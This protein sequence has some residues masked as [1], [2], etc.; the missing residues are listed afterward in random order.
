V[1]NT[2]EVINARGGFRVRMFICAGS[3]E[4]I[5]T[6][7]HAALFAGRLDA[8][9]FA[10]RV[11]TARNIARKLVYYTANDGQTYSYVDE[12]W[13]INPRYWVWEA[14]QTSAYAFMHERPT[15]S[16]ETV[17]RPIIRQAV[18]TN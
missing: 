18:M 3:D 9:A 10:D 15:A 14:N 5:E 16:Y 13:H 1:I 11:N 6:I 12:K 17:P 7:T 8:Q 4:M 2:A